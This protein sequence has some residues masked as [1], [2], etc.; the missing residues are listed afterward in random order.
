MVEKSFDELVEEDE[1]L[2]ASLA[3]EEDKAKI[4]E[5]K[6]RY[7]KDYL[8]VLGNSASRLVGGLKANMHEPP[9]LLRQK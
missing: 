5:Y 7:G 1:K 3:V 4:A 9:T 8:R 2:K 6:K